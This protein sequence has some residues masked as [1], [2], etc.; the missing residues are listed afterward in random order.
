MLIVNTSVGGAFDQ[1]HHSPFLTQRITFADVPFSLPSIVVG[2]IF[3][4]DHISYISSLRGIFSVNIETPVPETLSSN[5][6]PSRS[7][8][9]LQLCRSTPIQSSHTVSGCPSTDCIKFIREFY[10]TVLYVGFSVCGGGRLV[11]E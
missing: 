9:R 8:T 2:L 3:W 6:V 4:I 11:V 1:L 7:R 5:L 10:T